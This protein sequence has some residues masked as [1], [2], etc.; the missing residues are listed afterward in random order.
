CSRRLARQMIDHA[1]CVEHWQAFENP[2]FQV[3]QKV[4][5][6]ELTREKYQCRF[7]VPGDQRSECQVTNEAQQRMIDEWSKPETVVG[8]EGPTDAIPFRESLNRTTG[9]Y[10]YYEPVYAHDGCVVCHNHLGAG[11]AMAEN[12]AVADVPIFPTR[13]VEKGDLMAIAH[14]VLPFRETENEKKE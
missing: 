2:E 6:A 5:A 1:L 4:L 3:L 7:I 10:H 9:A 14:I 12:S 11:T 13:H 8:Q